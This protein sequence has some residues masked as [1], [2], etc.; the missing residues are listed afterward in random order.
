MRRSEG[1]GPA[2]ELTPAKACGVRLS[3]LASSPGDAL[4]RFD[5]WLPSLASAT[6]TQGPTPLPRPVPSTTM[7]S[8]RVDG[9]ERSVRQGGGGLRSCGR[10]VARGIL[11]ALRKRKPTF[12]R[13]AY[14]TLQNWRHSLSVARRTPAGFLT[15][16]AGRMAADSN[17]PPLA[18]DGRPKT[19]STPTTPRVTTT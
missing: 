18:V 6:G 1:H 17:P 19:C 10:A 12:P 14:C 13:N 16:P 7:L 11:T 2:R 9:L 4:K 3:M 8:M 5:Y 15:S